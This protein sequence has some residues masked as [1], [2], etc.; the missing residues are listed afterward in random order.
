[1]DICDVAKPVTVAFAAH[2]ATIARCL[3]SDMYRHER[4]DGAS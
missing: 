4:A 2:G 3:G 1:M